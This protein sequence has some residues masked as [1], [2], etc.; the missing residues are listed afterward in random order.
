MIKI[1]SHSKRSRIIR[2]IMGKMV[3][4]YK[5]GNKGAQRTGLYLF[6]ECA[7]CLQSLFQQNKTK[8]SFREIARLITRN[9]LK[10]S[11]VDWGGAC[12]KRRLA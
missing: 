10:N 3:L 11:F 6:V 12:G 1:K 8:V 9:P 4:I 5:L 2:Y 7:M